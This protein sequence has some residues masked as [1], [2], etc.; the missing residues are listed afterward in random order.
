MPYLP[1]KAFLAKSTQYKSLKA[2]KE[3]YDASLWTYKR[4]ASVVTDTQND[5][6]NPMAHAPRVNKIITGISGD[7]KQVPRKLVWFNDCV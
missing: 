5:Y 3:P 2:Y 6:H 4:A 1:N 7:E